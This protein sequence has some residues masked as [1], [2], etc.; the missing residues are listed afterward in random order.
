MREIVTRGVNSRSFVSVDR[1]GYRR[2]ENGNKREVKIARGRFV[3]G[4]KHRTKKAV[5]KYKRKLSL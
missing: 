1:M 3:S 5:E 2:V 4:E